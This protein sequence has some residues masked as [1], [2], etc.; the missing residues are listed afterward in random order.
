[1]C[2]HDSNRDSAGPLCYRLL[3]LLTRRLLLL[4]LQQQQPSCRP[5]HLSLRMGIGREGRARLLPSRSWTS[6][7][8]EARKGHW[9]RSSVQ[10]NF[11]AKINR[12]AAALSHSMVEGHLI[13]D[14]MDASVELPSKRPYQWPPL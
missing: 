6:A 5:A 14:S 11:I 3:P 9:Q 7:A 12:Q 8:T 4:L 10:K 2:K 13:A 1:M